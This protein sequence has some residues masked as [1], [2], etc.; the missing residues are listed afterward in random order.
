MKLGKNKCTIIGMGV[1][2]SKEKQTPYYFLEFMNEDGETITHIAYLT[3]ATKKRNFELLIQLGF[4]GKDLTD[5]AS[6]KH[7]D[8]VFIKINDPIYVI[9]ENEG[10]TTQTG[11]QK[12]RK[13]AKYVN[14]GERQGV[15]KVDK[16]KA[17]IISTTINA[18]GELAQARMKI[19]PNQDEIPF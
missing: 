10:Y 3:E 19:K 16:T 7:V 13:I 18:A 6:E 12:L 4:N 15:P 5:L 17:Q 9:V 1:G 11:E 2:E 14:V 8:E